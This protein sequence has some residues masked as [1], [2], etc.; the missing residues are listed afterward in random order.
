MT[1]DWYEEERQKR[2]NEMQGAWR[3]Q[4]E[5][6]DLFAEVAKLFCI[7]AVTMLLV[8]APCRGC[9]PQPRPAAAYHG[10]RV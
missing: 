9:E 1:R 7:A 4:T 5:R 10:I 2:L 8:G 6:R 3:S